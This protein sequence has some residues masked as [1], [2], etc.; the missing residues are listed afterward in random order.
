L[1]VRL[2]LPEHLSVGLLDLL[3]A[4]GRFGRAAVVVGMVELHEPPVRGTEFSVGNAA[5]DP[6][7]LVR[8]RHLM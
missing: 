8:I 5:V 2:A 6:E 1:G 4:T 3:E 7:C